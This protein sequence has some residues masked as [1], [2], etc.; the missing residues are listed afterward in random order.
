M[1]SFLRSLD[2]IFV[3]RPM[4]FFP[5]WS[6]LLAGY[7]IAYR[8]RLL[9]PPE[10]SLQAHAESIVLLLVSFAAAMGATFLLNQLRDIEGDKANRKLF[11][12]SKGYITHRAAVIEVM[13]LILLSLALGFYLSRLVGLLALFFI[14]LTG[15]LYNYRPFALK[16]RPWGSLWAN[17]AMGWAAFALGWAGTNE[18]F[19]AAIF[20]DSLPYLF[21]NTALYFYTTLPDMA[22]DAQ[23]Q[24]VT[25]AV[26]YGPDKIFVTAFFLYLSGLAAALLLQDY[27]ALLILV[28]SGP[29]F[30]INIY[31]RTIASAIRTTKFSILFF[32]LA[33]CLKIPAY[34]ILMVAGFFAT[35]AYF[36]ARFNFDY[37]NFKGQ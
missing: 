8:H 33:I 9:A 2:Y 25:L 28:L 36:K 23:H 30:V 31:A 27:T 24:K 16:D 34:F 21:L 3:L 37:P 7:L 22:G 15:F 1:S 11:I 13:L 20:S 5:G 35:R 32:A 10:F 26:R 17:S 19:D 29:F 14:A 4:L 18:H 6:T 12:I